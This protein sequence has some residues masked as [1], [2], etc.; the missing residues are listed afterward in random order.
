[1]AFQ[2]R[3]VVPWRF[4]VAAALL[5]LMLGAALSRGLAGE[6][7]FVLPGVRSGVSPHKGL[8]RLPLLAQGPISGVLGADDPAYRISASGGGFRAVSQVQRLRVRFG[9]ARVLLSSGTVRLGLS[10]RAVGY[11]ASM[12]AL[13]DVTP[14]SK[15]NRVIY[16]R[17]GLS[18][19]YVNGPLGLEQGFT[20]PRAPTGDRTGPLTLSMALSGNVHAA[21]TSDRQ[22]LTLSHT[23]GPSLRYGGLVASDAHGHALHSWLQLHAERVMLRIDTRGASYPLRIDPLIQQGPKLTPN[24]GN[25]KS[26]FGYSVALSADGNTA[27]I[28]GLSDNS[29]A[30]AAWVFTRSGSTWTQQAKLTGGEEVGESLFGT[31]AALS[32]DGNTALIGGF[33]DNGRVGAAWVFTRSGSTWTQQ[34]PKLTAKSGEE[35][36]EGGFG[37]RAALSADG[38]TALIG[39]SRDSSFVGAA[40]VLTRSGSTWTQQGPKLTAKSGEEIGEG[41]FGQGVALSADGNTALIGGYTDNGFVGAVWVFTRSGSAW[42]QEGS[43]LTGG[44][45]SGNGAFGVGV[46]LSSDGNTA[47]IGGWQDN[48]EAG[49]AW[50]FT[51]SG[52]TWTQQGSKLTGGEEIG[53]GSFGGGVALS[54]D[55]NTALIGGLAD[56]S[57]AGAAWVFT[58]SGSTW[59]QKGSKLT[60]GE[61]IG[62]G[63]FGD[64][65]AL[66]SDGNTALIGGNADNSEA[67]A[68]WVFANPPPAVQIGATPTTTTTTATL[69]P[70][71]PTITNASQSHRS[72]R[73]GKALA[74]FSRKHKRAP[75]GTTFSFT[76]NEQASVSF[77]FTQQLGGRKVNGKC[78]AQTN[79]NRRK[80]ACNRA[81][82]R[83]TLSFTGHAGTNKVFFQG[84]TSRTKKLKPGSYTLVITATN[85]TG[86]H[87][88]PKRLSFTIVK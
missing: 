74:S 18:E 62:K 21:L 71:R 79:K 58:R 61:E 69:A 31:S 14:S 51:R 52:S 86:Q 75:L 59:T 15:A 23:G 41:D 4:V 78:V 56:N 50:V 73:E 66:S 83:G 22:S 20:L 82:T 24:D 47:L 8:S 32:S 27:L 43:K 9:R 34:G 49:A 81:V 28:G 7:S 48:G 55:G 25:G 35:I 10:L 60:G 1:M 2:A 64:H 68:A 29:K 84:R 6:R 76:L 17:A 36:G 67:G 42:T 70:A 11:G 40:W 19:W 53:A 30:G 46:A 5:S 87:S 13:G 54:S 16:A 80:R 3:A 33:G 72:W 77:A 12:S 26:E 38:N 39:G 37:I 65:A 85:G 45:E 88:S 44:G 63:R 57:E